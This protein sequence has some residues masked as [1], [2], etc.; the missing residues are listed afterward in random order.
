[1]YFGLQIR[2]TNAPLKGLLALLLVLHVVYTAVQM[3]TTSLHTRLS[4]TS[5]VLNI[6]AIFAAALLSF[7]EDQRSVEP[8]DLIVIYFSVSSILS[9]ARLR[10]LWL[11]PSAPACRGL[12]TA[13]YILTVL[14]LLLESVIKTNLL[15]PVYRSLTKEQLIGFWG[16]SFFVWVLP[17][18]HL[19]YSKVF[20]VEDLPE[21]DQALQGYSAEKKLGASWH[22][23]KGPRRLL[24][25]TL[26]AYMWPLVSGI[27]PRLCV[28][29]FTFCQPFLINATVNF[30]ATT[31]TTPESKKYGQALVGGYALVY[32]GLTVCS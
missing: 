9:I 27:G 17:I 11:I 14:A 13:L 31:T 15:R 5:A 25:A 30:M 19:G 2:L 29:V 20:E 16:R 3:R 10:S 21:V 26:D 12:W 18:F 8:S 4:T 32:L 24:K 28:T 7:M 23:T 22:Q 1:V 6:F